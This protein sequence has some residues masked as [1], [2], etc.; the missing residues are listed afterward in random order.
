[1]S[2]HEPN[3]AYARQLAERRAPSRSWSVFWIRIAI[4]VM[5]GALV[6]AL[7]MGKLS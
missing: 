2:S 4:V 3:W 7:L 1:M 6:G 5:F